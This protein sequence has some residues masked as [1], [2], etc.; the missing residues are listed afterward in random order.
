MD[1]PK[2]EVRCNANHN[3]QLQ[4]KTHALSV[5]VSQLINGNGSDAMW[6][7]LLVIC[8]ESEDG[9]LT[10]KVIVCHPDWDQNLQVASIR[11]CIGEHGKPAGRVELDL[12]QT[13][14]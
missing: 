6:Q 8:E 13:R 3:G 5:A 7:A 10:T 11:S 9:S 2:F 12:K 14:V 1:D 4:V